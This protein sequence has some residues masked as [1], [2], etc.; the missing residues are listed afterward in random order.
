MVAELAKI[1]FNS[2]LQEACP[3]FVG[4]DDENGVVSGDCADDL[5]PVFIVDSGSDGLGASSGRDQDEQV[6]G[7]SYFKAEAF[8]DLSY[9]R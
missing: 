7:L 8:E 1:S 5:R 2:G 9:S 6:H 4:A 3:I